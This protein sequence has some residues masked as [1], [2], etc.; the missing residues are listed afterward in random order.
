MAPASSASPTAMAVPSSDSVWHWY[1]RCAHP[2]L[3]RLEFIFDRRQVYSSVFNVCRLNR[4]SIG[5]EQPQR[6]LKFDLQSTRRSL[7]GEQ[8]GLPLEGNVWEAGRD[9]RGLVLGVSFAGRRRVWLNSLHALDPEK[10]SETA[11][12]RGLVLR[13]IPGPE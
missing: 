4:N 12:A 6:L 1:A 8:R 13:T 2:K 5:P 9:E 7:F 10:A 11:L 3:I